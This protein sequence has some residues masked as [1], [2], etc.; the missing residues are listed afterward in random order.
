MCLTCYLNFTQQEFTEMEMDG[1]RVTINSESIKAKF[2]SKNLQTE[3]SHMSKLADGYLNFLKEPHK[4]ALPPKEDIIV[5]CINSGAFV[6]LRRRLKAVTLI[7]ENFPIT[8]QLFKS[9][10]IIRTQKD[11]HLRR[12]Y[13]MI[14]PFSLFT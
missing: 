14:H 5:T 12:H 2:R 6:Y 1:S 8:M 3:S 10:S 9:N 13:Y 7:N 4:C 11:R